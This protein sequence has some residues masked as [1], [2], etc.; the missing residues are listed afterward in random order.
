MYHCV[1]GTDDTDSVVQNDL[2]EDGE[3]SDEELKEEKKETVKEKP[4]RERITFSPNENKKSYYIL[5]WKFRIRKSLMRR[6]D[7]E[8]GIHVDQMTEG[9]IT[10]LVEDHKK[11]EKG[12]TKG[13]TNLPVTNIF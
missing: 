4:K 11:T 7:D 6:R 12:I 2:L 5:K 9:G 13:T 10:H 1:G 3:I 8:R